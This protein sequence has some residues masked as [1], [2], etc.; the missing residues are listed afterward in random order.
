M[1]DSLV[2]MF[3]PSLDES[4]DL[5]IPEQS[6]DEILEIGDMLATF[7]PNVFVYVTGPALQE[8]KGEA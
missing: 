3:L 8:W 7:D 4:I 2:K 6:F 1:T 5:G